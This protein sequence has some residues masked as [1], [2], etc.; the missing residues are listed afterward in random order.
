VL[1][2]GYCFFFYLFFYDSWGFL[3]ISGWFL[4]VLCD[5]L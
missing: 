1:L 4:V 3:G 2:G 5:S